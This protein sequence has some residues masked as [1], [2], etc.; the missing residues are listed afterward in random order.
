MKKHQYFMASKHFRIHFGQFLKDKTL[1]GSVL[2]CL[3]ETVYTLCVSVDSFREILC[4][5][6]LML[7]VQEAYLSPLVTIMIESNK[8]EK[9]K[10]SL[11]P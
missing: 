2:F 8:S 4:Y 1:I 5:E 6:N 11:E 7:T 3:Q 9:K 10:E